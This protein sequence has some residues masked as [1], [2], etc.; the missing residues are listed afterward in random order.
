MKQLFAKKP[1]SLLLEEMKGENRLRRIL[2]PVA[3]TSLGV[4]AIIGT[5]IFVLTGVAAHD[6]AGPAIILSFVISGLAC[7]FAALCYAEFASMVPVAGSAYTYAYATLGEMFAWIIGWDLILEYAVASATVAHGWSHYFQDFIGIF[8]L[9]IPYWA[10]RAPFD[11]NP[12]TGLL[13]GTGTAIDLPAIIIAAIITIILVKGI[14]ESASF[15]ATMVIIKLIIVFFVIIVGAFYINT[16]NWTNNFAPFGWSGISFFGKTVFGQTGLGGAPVG[17]I[18]A[19]ATI[20]FAYIGFDSISTHAEEAK[21]PR[22]DVPI[23]IIASLLLCTVLYIAV[24]AIIT[25]MVPYDKIDIDAPVSNAF[26][27]VGLPWAQLIISFGALAGITSVL[28]VMMLSQPRIFLAMARDGLLPKDV[29]GSVH[30]KYRTPWK[31]TIL[32]GIFVAILA[33]LLP[34]RI[35]AELVNIGTLFAFVI[36]CAAVLIMRRT[37]PEAERPFKAPWVPFV[38]VAGILTCLMLMFSLP[39]ENWLRLFVWLA[40]GFVIYFGYGRKHSVMHEY[41][42]S[43][44]Q[45]K[46]HK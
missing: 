4:G 40:I 37:H 15:N 17:M 35:L 29:F 8:G 42:T 10:T 22:R 5:G 27:Q 23:G 28:L 34:L 18:A 30:E 6:K 16:Q 32:T 44:E 26:K 24:S 11:F 19:A 43:H 39:E 21:N 45:E 1:L 31:S 2:G 20:F 25:G 36:V 41:M 46:V 9:R 3:L 38:P 33:G 7:V 14:R 12:D 13:A